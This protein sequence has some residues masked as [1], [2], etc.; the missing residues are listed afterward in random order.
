MCL[1]SC[2][3][4]HFPAG[5]HQAN[6]LSV[7]VAK[8]PQLHPQNVDISTVLDNE[9]NL[10]GEKLEWRQSI[11][12][13]M[14][15]LRLDPGTDARKRLA[16]G[17]GYDGDTDDSWTMNIWLSSYVKEVVAAVGCDLTGWCIAT[18]SPR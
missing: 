12:D 16:L 8:E 10:R 4:Y 14:K 9:A 11:V 15:V 3:Q 1:W 13:L 6:P 7:P 18:K 17:A 2:K 5:A